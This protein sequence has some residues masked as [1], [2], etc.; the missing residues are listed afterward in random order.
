MKIIFV[1]KKHSTQHYFFRVVNSSTHISNGIRMRPAFTL[2]ELLV[3]IGI[4]GIIAATT[5]P[6]YGAIRQSVLLNAAARQLVSTLREAQNK[7][8]AS[9]DNSPFGVKFSGTQY[10]LYRVSPAQDIR[11]VDTTLAISAASPVVFTRLSGQATPVNIIL[12][13]GHTKTISVAINGLISVSS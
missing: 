4:I 12:G 7:S 3:T 1:K 13:S 9:Q 8:I 10:T 6:A 2:M 5:I 11:T